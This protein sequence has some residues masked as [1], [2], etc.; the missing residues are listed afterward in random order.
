M[1]ICFSKFTKKMCYYKTLPCKMCPFLAAYQVYFV[2]DATR[3]DDYISFCHLLFL[4]V[5]H[6]L[7]SPA[8]SDLL[9]KLFH[10]ITGRLGQSFARDSATL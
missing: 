6:P 3:K 7:T 2:K 4:T 10:A 8:D 9:T 1:Y 5:F